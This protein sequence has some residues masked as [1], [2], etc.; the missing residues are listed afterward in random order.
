MSA[1]L[2]MK[3]LCAGALFCSTLPAGAEEL[4]VLHYWTSGGESRAVN[5]L[6]EEIEQQ[7]HVWKDSA[8]AGGGGQNAMTVLKTRAIAG[9]PP[10]AGRPDRCLDGHLAAGH[11]ACGLGGQQQADADGHSPEDFRRRR[12]VPKRR[13]RVVDQRMADEVNRHRFNI[14]RVCQKGKRKRPSSPN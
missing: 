4:E 13:E 2:V 6:K 9:D 12:P 7:G 10:A 14:Q 3:A 1:K 11:V 8:I 5:V